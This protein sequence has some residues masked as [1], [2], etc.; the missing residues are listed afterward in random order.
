MCWSGSAQPACG[1]MKE[2]T[3]FHQA[4]AAHFGL[5]MLR[6]EKFQLIVWSRVPDVS[7]ERCSE[8]ISQAS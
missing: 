1:E 6:K 8:N 7:A 4:A 2:T 3:G 5:Q